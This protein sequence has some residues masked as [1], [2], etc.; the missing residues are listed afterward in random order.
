M[1]MCLTCGKEL[2]TILS[3]IGHVFCSFD[4]AQ[5][6]Y[7]ILQRD[8]DKRYAEALARHR[9]SQDLIKDL[10]QELRTLQKELQAPSAQAEG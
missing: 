7:F 3:N 6:A 1:A 10:R 2:R 8:S 9:Q 4:C 5:D